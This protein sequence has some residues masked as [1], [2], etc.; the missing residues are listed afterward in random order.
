MSFLLSDAR[1]AHRLREAKG[2]I[3]G[4]LVGARLHD[5]LTGSL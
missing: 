1:I 5:F 2:K 3:A 4:L